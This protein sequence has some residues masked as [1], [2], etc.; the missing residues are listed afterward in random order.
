MGSVHMVMRSSDP[1]GERL[2]LCPGRRVPDTAAAGSATGAG[3]V[4]GIIRS[5]TLLPLALSVPPL[6]AI[7][8]WAVVCLRIRRVQ[9]TQPSVLDGLALPAPV[10]ADG[11]R[12]LVSVVIPAHNEA[13][14]IGACVRSLLAQTWS[15]IEIIFALDRCT[16]GTEDILRS[17]I[18][19][20]PRVRIVRIDMCPPEWAGKCNAA[21]RG[22]EVAR[23][24]WI[25]F[26]DA[27][28]QFDPRLVEASV[29]LADA[30]GLDL[31][32]LLSTLTT[33]HW[34]E[35]VVQP[36]ASLALLRM[37][38][39][40]RVNRSVA[41]RAFANGQFLLFRRRAY[42]GLGGHEAVRT[43]LLEDIAF[44]RAIV[45]RGG[46][47]GMAIAEGMLVVSMYDSID[48]FRRGWQRILIEAAGRRPG[49]LRRLAARE[50]VVGVIQPVLGLGAIAGGLAGIACH[51]GSPVSSSWPW[52]I[53]II[54]G[55]VSLLAQAVGLGLFYR[56][57]GTPLVGVLLHPIGSF[58]T[59]RI[60]R[61]AARMLEQRRPVRWGGRE[62]V[63]TP[64][65][66]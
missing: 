37:F 15:P 46:C 49:R 31:F 28:V 53:V 20:D 40:D 48:A 61:S 66:G 59:A 32:S 30:R 57:A 2:T 13:R 65:P 42:D 60:M 39:L 33:A 16:D 52:G 55:A 24:A 36:I 23:G 43:D 45:A 8:Y 21:R 38:P 54:V 50:F 12:P 26:T 7:V 63:I 1:V 10:G 11:T 4:R 17:A 47:I 27:D 34:F 5:V 3:P 35:R 25:L 18:G 51:D 19:D 6:L 41:P 56:T 64:E 22:A 29:A 62:Y 14:V 58:E 9:S 44:A